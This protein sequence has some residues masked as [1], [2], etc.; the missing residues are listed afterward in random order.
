MS[1]LDSG[2]RNNAALLAICLI[3]GSIPSA[4]IASNA[5]LNTSI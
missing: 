4:R 5:L 1:I 3:P 2:I